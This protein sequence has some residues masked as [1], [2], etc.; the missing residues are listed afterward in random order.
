MEWHHVTPM[1]S[2]DLACE[3]LVKGCVV[4]RRALCRL[5]QCRQTLVQEKEVRRKG[6]EGMAG[7]PTLLSDP[8][9]ALLAV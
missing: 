1:V 7:C 8:A 3:L 9:L 4:L 2:M 6:G 5:G